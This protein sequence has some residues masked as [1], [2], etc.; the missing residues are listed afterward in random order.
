MVIM[1]MMVVTMMVVAVRRRHIQA[2]VLEVQLHVRQEL[3]LSFEHETVAL[4][5]IST[6]GKNSW[7]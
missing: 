6:G 5:I 2:R 1:M 4:V 3:V 7:C